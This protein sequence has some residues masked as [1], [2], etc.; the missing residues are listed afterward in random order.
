MAQK[1]SKQLNLYGLLGVDKG[2]TS[3]EIKSAYKKLAL[4]SI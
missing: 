1:S 3:V 2:A 4:V